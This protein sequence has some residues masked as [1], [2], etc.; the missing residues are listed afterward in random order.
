M[1][2]EVVSYSFKFTNTGKSDLVISDASA[3]CGCT[4]AHKPEDPV[5]P[6]EQAAIDVSFDSHNRP[7]RVDKKITIIANTIPNT[8]VIKI[9]GKV[10]SPVK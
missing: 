9:T 3:S 5:P 1:E 2:G 8:T 7:G 4:I 6:G 10:I